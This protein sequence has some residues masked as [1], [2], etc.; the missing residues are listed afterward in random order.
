M[1]SKSLFVILTRTGVKEFIVSRIDFCNVYR[2]YV[3]SGRVPL[4]LGFDHLILHTP[5]PLF[6]CMSYCR[7]HAARTYPSAYGKVPHVV[8]ERGFHRWGSYD[9]GACGKCSDIYFFTKMVSNISK[10]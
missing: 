1:Q 5:P 10:R 7:R 9:A 8:A 4:G 3:A 2:G 6:P